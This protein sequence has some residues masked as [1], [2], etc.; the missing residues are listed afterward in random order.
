M[1]YKGDVMIKINNEPC[2]PYEVIGKVFDKYL[3]KQADL[4]TVF[5][6]MKEYELFNHKKKEYK[7]TIEYKTTCIKLLIEE[8]D[9]EAKD[10]SMKG[11]RF[12]RLKKEVK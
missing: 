10:V 12:P 8:L 7:M 9:I 1:N 5:D 11:V 4:Y 3:E 6:G 2:L